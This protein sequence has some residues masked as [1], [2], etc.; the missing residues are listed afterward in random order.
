MSLVDKL[1]MM[2][3]NQQAPLVFQNKQDP[4]VIANQNLQAISLTKRHQKLNQI[5][6]YSSKVILEDAGTDA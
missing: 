3:G 5:P 4:S 2:V 1:A 6:P